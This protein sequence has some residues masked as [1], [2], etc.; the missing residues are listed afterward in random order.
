MKRLLLV[1]LLLQL[2]LYSCAG[3]KMTTPRRD[4]EKVVTHKVGYGET[5]KSISRDFYSSEDKARDLAGY[6]GSDM[7]TPPR[8]G[9]AV[10]IPLSKD[11]LRSL[12]SRLDAA[13]AYN[14]GL[15][16][17]SKQ[18]YG[19]AVE[20]FQCAL[21]IDP[22]FSDAAF[23]LAVTYKKLGLYGH[24]T[25]VLNE[26]ILRHPANVE[27]RFA[28]GNAHFHN[29]ELDKALDAFLAVRSMDPGHIKSL[30][31]LAV[32]YEKTGNMEG[33]KRL[34]REYL[35]QD[36]ESEWAEQA[37]SRLESLMRA[38]GGDP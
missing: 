20:R 24:A 11:D 2:A 37:R 13:E 22:Q 33:A 36:T 5:W 3:R 21:E 19:K 7:D 38:G 35:E 12:S 25:S 28:L 31:S 6:N 18:D 15:E 4:A 29:G 1:P 26:L 8:A 16:L 32:I 34:W 10:R 23:N 14:E 9:S 27:Y 17:I 30:F